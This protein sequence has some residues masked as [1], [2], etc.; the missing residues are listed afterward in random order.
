MVQDWLLA[1]A[2]PKYL[3]CVVHTMSRVGVGVAEEA[4]P[5][6]HFPI[7]R[8]CRGRRRLSEKREQDEAN[9]VA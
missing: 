7:D 2:E 6:H 3:Q 9:G 1:S 4:E 8:G 5:V